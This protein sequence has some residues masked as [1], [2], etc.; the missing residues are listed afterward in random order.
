MLYIAVQNDYKLNFLMSYFVTMLHLI[1][2]F[3]YIYS[4]SL[5]GGKQSDIICTWVQKKGV[6]H[7]S[8]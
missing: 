8:R 6:P 1:L 5:T 2:H 3:H 7:L 4:K